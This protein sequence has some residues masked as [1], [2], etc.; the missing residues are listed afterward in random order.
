MAI[1]VSKK[2][3]EA[4]RAICAFDRDGMACAERRLH[5]GA[6]ECGC[7]RWER[8]CNYAG[9]VF[10]AIKKP[11]KEM[12][13]AGEGAAEL[14]LD[15]DTS[16]DTESGE[17]VCYPNAALLADEIWDAMWKAVISG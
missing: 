11:S 6:T 12:K 4:A 2:T 16:S 17:R 10:D 13:D 5:T 9:A 8:W 14:R 15:M 1:I 7:A 3:E